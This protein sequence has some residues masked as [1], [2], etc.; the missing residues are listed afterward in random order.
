MLIEGKSREGGAALAKYLQEE[1]NAGAKVLDIR[2]AGTQPD[3]TE[4]LR[5]WDTS[6]EPQTPRNTSTTCRSTRR[7]T[8]N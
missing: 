3:L 1:K 4:A 5:E 7:M 2:Y 6:A 8:N